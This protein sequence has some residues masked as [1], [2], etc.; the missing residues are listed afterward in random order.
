MA[1][2]FRLT[3]AIGRYDLTDFDSR[4]IAP[5]LP[6]K[7]RGVSRVDERRVLNGIFRVLRAGAP[8]RDLPG[9]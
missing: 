1:T 4:V 9:R 8:R 2:A 5:L 6:Y 7:P 3:L